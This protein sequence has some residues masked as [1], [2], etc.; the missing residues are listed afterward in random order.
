MKWYQ[1]DVEADFKKLET[2]VK[3]LTEAEAADRIQKYGP[4]KL[5]EEGRISRWKLLLHQFTSPLI[6]ILMLA[7]VVTFFLEEY[8]DTGVIVAVILLNAFIG[9]TQELKAENNVRALKKLVVA[10][11]RV[12]RDSRQLEI[13]RE[14]LVPGVMVVLA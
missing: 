5:A 3:G 1:I 10:K 11:A 4:N 7:A 14:G 6:Y 8:K 12:I 2:S 9:Y 13:D